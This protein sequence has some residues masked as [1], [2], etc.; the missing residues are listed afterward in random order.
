MCKRGELGRKLAEENY[1]LN[2][3]NKK[4]TDLYQKFINVKNIN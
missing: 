4:I 1:D 2:I 3:Y